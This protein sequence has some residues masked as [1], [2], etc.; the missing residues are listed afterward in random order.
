MDRVRDDFVAAVRRA[1]EAGFDLVELHMAHGYLLSSFLSPLSNLRADAYGGTLDNRMRFPV[2]VLRAARA[3]WPADRPLAVRISAS[4][5]LD[6]GGQTPAD[7]V[8]IARAF[9][10]EGCDLIDVSSA[11]N[12]PLSKPVYGRMYQV[13]FADRI[14]QETGVAVMA[15]GGIQDA[16]QANTVIAAGR[17]D[18]CAIARA[19]LGDPYITA[20]EAVRYGERGVAWPMQYA[21]GRPRPSGG[22]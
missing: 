22:A 18:L 17:A 8:E 6:G 21:A 7:S 16:D 11:G 12:S 2:E 20:R 4:D 10:A 5:W 15:V 9:A 3:A 1:A 19:H 14:R 13:P